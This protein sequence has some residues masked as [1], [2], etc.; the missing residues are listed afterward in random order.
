MCLVHWDCL[1][2]PENFTRRCM[3]DPAHAVAASTLEYVLGTGQVYSEG[4]PRCSIRV[5]NRDAR[6]EVKDRVDTLAAIAHEFAV[7]EVAAPN[8][9]KLAARYI[10]EKAEAS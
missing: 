1:S 9:K 2:R 7:Q 5:R 8:L 10:F 4:V 6:A 3:N